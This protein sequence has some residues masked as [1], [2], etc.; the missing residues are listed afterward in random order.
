MSEDSL[1]TIWFVNNSQV[2]G[3]V[4]IYQNA[5]A[6]LNCAP[7]NILTLAWMVYGANPGGQVKFTWTIDYEFAWFNQTVPSSQ[8]FATPALGKQVV[9]SANQYGYEFLQPESSQSEECTVAT[10][11]S[12]PAINNL[13]AGI[14][15]NRAGTFAVNAQPN[16]KSTFIP[17][18]SASLT[19]L[20]S[21]GYA[22]ALNDV[23]T[24]SAMNPPGTI[25]FP[26]GVYVM[27]AVYNIDGTWT[28]S[29]GAPKMATQRASR[30]RPV[31]VPV[32]RAGCGLLES[33]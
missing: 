33:P 5:S 4:C 29:T 8:G 12:I 17:V 19:Y 22:G 24:L 16:I 18:Q 26:S 15:M 9:L 27:T 14:A 1:F 30:S 7:D 6:N 10:D 3:N 25:I 13:V 31:A 23:L 20:I 32:Y 11:S 28:I 2:G 21:F